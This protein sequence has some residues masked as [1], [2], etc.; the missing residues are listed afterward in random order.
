[1]ANARVAVT[2]PEF[3]LA[4][5]KGRVSRQM[6]G[7]GS[8]SSETGKSWCCRSLCRGLWAFL[9]SSVGE[10]RRVEAGGALGR[11][12]GRQRLVSTIPGKWLEGT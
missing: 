1:M 3:R 7:S 4:K 6:E 2:K 8:V 9:R 10:T 12:L 5:T 11:K